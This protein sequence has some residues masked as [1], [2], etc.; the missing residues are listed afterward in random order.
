M[1]LAE[2]FGENCSEELDFKLQLLYE[3]SRK[4]PVSNWP[5]LPVAEY[6]LRAH[7]LESQVARK[8]IEREV[9]AAV[10]DASMQKLDALQDWNSDSDSDLTQKHSGADAFQRLRAKITSLGRAVKKTAAPLTDTANVRDE[11]IYRDDIS[12]AHL[13]ASVRRETCISQSQS[14]WKRTWCKLASSA[15]ILQR[16]VSKLVLEIRQASVDL[17]DALRAVVRSSARLLEDIADKIKMNMGQVWKR[18][19]CFHDVEY[20]NAVGKIWANLVRD[21][22]DA[23]RIAACCTVLISTRF[24]KVGR[25]LPAK[26]ESDTAEVGCIKSEKTL[27]VAPMESE[28]LTVE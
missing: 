22:N 5:S 6:S 28:G 18:V 2:T 7:E 16:P 8:E 11:S 23:L 25:S 12:S 27:G 10:A 15:I 24:D 4:V 21:K 13:T 3:D 19:L 17:G 14:W 26:R 20:T 9:A 1:V